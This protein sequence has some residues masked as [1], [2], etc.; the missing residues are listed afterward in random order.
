MTAPWKSLERWWASP[1]RWRRALPVAVLLAA[2]AAN[3]GYDAA[4][5]SGTCD[6][7]GAHIPCGHLYWTSGRF[8]GGLGNPPLGQLLIALPVKLLGRPYELYTEQHLLLFRLPVLL[9]GLALAAAVYAFASELFGRGAALVALFL[10]ALS[11]NVLAHSALATLDLPAACFCFLAV[12]LLHRYVRRPGVVRLLAFS[13]ALAAALLTKVQGVLLLPIAAA[14]V[15]LSAGRFLPRDRRRRARLM[16]SWALV[17]LTVVVLVHLAYLHV[18]RGL[19]GWLP[20]QFLAAVR[21]KFAHG[22]GGHH[23]YL[24]GRYSEAGW[25]YYFPVA[26]ALKTPLPALALI[27]VGLARRPSR[28]AAGFVLVPAGVFLAAGMVGRINIGLRHV[29]PVY[30][31]LFVV[32]GCGARRL[33]RAAWGRIVLALLLAGYLAQAIFI[34]PHHLSYFNLAAGGPG[35]GHKLLLDSNYDWGQ[36]DRFLRRHLRRRPRPYRINPDP[37][38]PIGGRVLVNA[39]ALYGILGSGPEAYAWLRGRRPVGRIAYTWFEY[40]VPDGQADRDRPEDRLR[41][42]LLAHV[43]DLRQRHQRLWVPPFRV[44]LAEVLFR[45]HAYDLVLEDMRALLRRQPACAPALSLA[46]ELT[47]KRK[48]GVLRF[49]GDEYLAGFRQTQPPG[50]VPGEAEVVEIARRGGIGAD[51][52]AAYVE[53]GAA[54]LAEGDRRAAESAFRTALRF[55]PASPAARAAVRRHAGP[56]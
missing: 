1:S 36:N 32:A 43:L 35:N 56:G 29:L 28:A 30:P 52:A 13:A 55:D 42:R 20:P 6:E 14:A 39:N 51:F 34:A 10:L 9:M 3:A 41:A 40:D 19:G 26:I 2:F 22:A 31:F 8:S 5:H 23:N 49:E 46:G 53:L 17:P 18:P 47:V 24:L 44:R 27:A 16:A 50:P 33:W 4:V 54:L 25:W 15:W 11:P 48:L 45:L 7:L 12:W 21:E 38:R 37:L